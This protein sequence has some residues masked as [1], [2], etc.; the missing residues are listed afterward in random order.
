MKFC[1]H[2]RNRHKPAR[3]ALLCPTATAKT[4]SLPSSRITP[5]SQ[6][7]RYSA[8]KR[9]RRSSLIQSG[10]LNGYGWSS[11]SS[12]GRG[13]L[14]AG[15]EVWSCPHAGSLAVIGFRATHPR[16]ASAR[17]VA[18]TAT[19]SCSAASLSVRLRARFRSRRRRCRRV[20][21]RSLTRFPC[22]PNRGLS[23]CACEAALPRLSGIN[24]C[25][26]VAGV[27]QADNVNVVA[28]A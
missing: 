10:R 8:I 28:D 20:S 16:G 2:D 25:I 21:R 14:V 5:A 26:A 23:N 9:S 17:A 7:R 6:W 1:S 4:T 13:T 11:C 12:R 24:A 19:G 18:S 3:T 22:G 27:E 15:G